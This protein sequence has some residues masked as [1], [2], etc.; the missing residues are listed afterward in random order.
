VRL[1]LLLVK[2]LLLLLLPLGALVDRLL[3][4]G[5]L[6]ILFS[7]VASNLFRLLYPTEETDFDTN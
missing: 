3:L 1:T 4:V 6:Y 2:L 7:V 5:H